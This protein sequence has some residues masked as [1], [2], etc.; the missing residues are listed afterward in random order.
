MSDNWM[1]TPT[2]MAAAMEGI[3]ENVSYPLADRLAAAQQANTLLH[4]HIDELERRHDA[5]LNLLNHLS[6]YDR[7]S[8]FDLA[9]QI[10]DL[11]KEQGSH[12]TR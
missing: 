11:L 7:E 5:V 10:R 1:N 2:L 6:K 4:K 3:S 12:D 8:A 9:D